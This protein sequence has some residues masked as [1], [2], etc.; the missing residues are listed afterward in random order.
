[1]SRTSWNKG[2]KWSP[3]IKAKIGESLKGKEPW[4]KGKV[5][6]MPVPWNKGKAWSEETKK[7]ISNSRKGAT[8]WNAGLKWDDETKV[9]IKESLKKHYEQRKALVSGKANQDQ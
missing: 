1:M 2:K 6:M 9:K 4:N 8:P 5:G 7:K 3:E